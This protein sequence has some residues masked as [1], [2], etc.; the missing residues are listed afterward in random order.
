MGHGAGDYYEEDYIYGKESFYDENDYNSVECS[1][2]DKWEQTGH[3]LAQL[4]SSL[5]VDFT[6]AKLSA[7]GIFLD[8]NQVNATKVPPPGR[9]LIETQDLVPL[10]I[11]EVQVQAVSHL[12]L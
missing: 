8:L 2:E 1:E 10:F 12:K 5:Q 9:L 7:K 11:L 4:L 3:V 6:S